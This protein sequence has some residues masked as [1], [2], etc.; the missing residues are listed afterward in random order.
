MSKTQGLLLERPIDDSNLLSFQ[1]NYQKTPHL[2]PGKTNVY[3]ILKILTGAN[4]RPKFEPISNFHKF[5]FSAGI[6]PG[7]RLSKVK[8]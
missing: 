1:Q 6:F 8:L 7:N 4:C 2:I 5:I 3:V